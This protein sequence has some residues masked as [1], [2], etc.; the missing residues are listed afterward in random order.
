[1]REFLDGR[2]FTAGI[3]VALQRELAM[4]AI[5]QK[6]VFFVV[7]IILLGVFTNCHASISKIDDLLENAIYK[8]QYQD[9]TLSISPERFNFIVDNLTYIINIIDLSEPRFFYSILGG[10]F[11]SYQISGE[12][13]NFRIQSGTSE[14]E[15]KMIRSGTNDIFYRAVAETRKFHVPISG[16]IGIKLHLKN[17]D[18]KAQNCKADVT[19]AFRPES[20]IM[21]KSIKPF[22]KTFASEMDEVTNQV[23]N[24]T[25]HFFTILQEKI[26]EYLQSKNLVFQ[27]SSLYQKNKELT[28]KLYMLKSSKSRLQPEV[29]GRSWLF[30][31]ILL[32]IG[33]LFGGVIGF[34]L[35]DRTRKSRTHRLAKSINVNLTRQKELDEKLLEILKE[36][37]EHRNASRDV[38]ER[39]LKLLENA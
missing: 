27:V 3:P 24:A 8:K 37:E 10:R 38:A 13:D 12:P 5:Y 17:S 29:G 31:I 28:E 21:A 33:G 20:A 26:P 34:F 23:I 18:T 25:T 14:A 16:Q 1:L 19:V 35:S 2:R 30:Y 22:S 9:L 6:K 11:A 36:Y 32:S 39:S 4:N 15:V 7:M